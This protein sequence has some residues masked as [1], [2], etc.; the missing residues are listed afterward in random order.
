MNGYPVDVPDEALL[1]GHLMR[2]SATSKIGHLLLRCDGIVRWGQRSARK[3]YLARQ[4]PCQILKLTITQPSM[5]QAFQGVEVN[6]FHVFHM[7][8]FA[9]SQY[10]FLAN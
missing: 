3:L 1:S 10:F 6:L 5:P 8:S 4:E 7:S 2:D 9:L